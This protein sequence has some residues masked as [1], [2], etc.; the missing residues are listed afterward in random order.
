MLRLD[1]LKVLVVEDEFLLSLCLQDDLTEVGCTIAGAFN[2]FAGALEAARQEAF[3]IAILDV[4][5]NGEP[6]FPLADELTARGVPFVLLTGY[7]A[8]DLPERFA[9]T[10]RLPKPYDPAMLVKEVKKVARHD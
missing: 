6:I 2:T 5:L 3:D 7:G 1:G 8:A 10:P 4:N 9:T